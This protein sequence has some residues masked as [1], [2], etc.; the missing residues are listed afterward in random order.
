MFR[1]L[2]AGFLVPVMLSGAFAQTAPEQPP[3]TQTPAVQPQTP[4]QMPAPSVPPMTFEWVKEGPAE[5]CGDRCRE[6]ISATGQIQPNTARIFVE[7]LQGK[8]AAGKT[9][10]LHS[11]GGAVGGGIALGRLFRRLDVTTT[12]GRTQ[13]LPPAADSSERAT[14]SP[15]GVCGSMCVF[16]LLG[17]QRRHV[18]NEARVLVHQIWPRANSGDAAA[19]TYSARD[20]VGVQRELGALAKYTVEM[21]GEIELFEIALRIPPWENLK[22]LDAIDIERVKL[23]NVANPFDPSAPS[24]QP[25]ALITVPVNRPLDVVDRAWA[26]N[27]A[28]GPRAFSRRHPLTIEGEQIGSF[29]LSFVCSDS[30]INAVY[31]ETRRLRS[32]VSLDKV[33][34]VGIGAGN[35]RAM[36]R[37]D[38]SAAETG[39]AELRT[40]A[41]GLVPPE[42]LAA[43]TDTA[44]QTLIV[45][46]QTETNVR[47]AIRP[48]NTG[49]GDSFKQT[50][51]GCAKQ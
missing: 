5:K 3:A 2:T 27:D 40:V 41:Q 10:V 47:T 19:G 20:L 50:V 29:E 26:A 33:S 34:R 6:W 13:K 14:L 8:S 38:K 24:I 30:G 45:A 17:G 21:G 7:F 12:V 28:Y 15:Q 46:T 1:K 35:A 43:V 32:N 22:P 39:S 16:V 48:G 31:V 25:Q 9:V 44:G 11:S 18:P 42:F 23:K 51:A 49:F 4:S 37:V 36:L